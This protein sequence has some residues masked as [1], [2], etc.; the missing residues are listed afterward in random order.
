MLH[1]AHALLRITC[2]TS[3]INSER[4]SKTRFNFGDCISVKTEE[5]IVM[6]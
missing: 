2:T 5:Q 6:K 3:E 4:G 1:H